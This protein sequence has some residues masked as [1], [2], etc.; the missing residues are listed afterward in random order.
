M[1][2]LVVS[3]LLL[4][5]FPGCVRPSIVH[6]FTGS[7]CLSW[8]SGIDSTTAKGPY[9]AINGKLIHYAIGGVYPHRPEGRAG[10]F[11]RR[12]GHLPTAQHLGNP[13]VLV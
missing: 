8:A 3:R 12:G 7:V 2:P 9:S 11:R 13:Y 5:F 10:V 6:V 4:C 1:W